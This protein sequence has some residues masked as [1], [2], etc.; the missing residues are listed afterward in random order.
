MIHHASC[1][2][3]N[4][5]SV[6]L[7][8]LKFIKMFISILC[9]LKTNCYCGTSMYWFNFRL[10]K[11]SRMRLLTSWQSPERQ[12]QVDSTWGKSSL[13]LLTRPFTQEEKLTPRL[14]SH[15]PTKISWALSPSPILI[16]QPTLDTWQGDMMLNT[17]ATWWVLCSFF[18]LLDLWLFIFTSILHLLAY[19]S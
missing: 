2:A 17:M 16:C 4:F 12:M 13:E 11:H 15:K 14:S 6:V 10:V 7:L 18:F 3:G 9:L 8:D 1:T 5:G 19:L